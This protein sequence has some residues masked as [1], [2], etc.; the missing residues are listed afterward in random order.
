MDQVRRP[1]HPSF[2]LLSAYH[3]AEASS[4]EVARVYF[5]VDGHTHVAVMLEDD[6]GGDLY[7]ATGRFY[8]FGP[9][10]IEPLAARE[11]AR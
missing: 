6:P 5:D 3:D 7:S 10:E 11:E 1:V 4:A 8:Y 9:E 2:E